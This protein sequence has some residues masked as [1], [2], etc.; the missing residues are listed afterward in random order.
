MIG[1]ETRRSPLWAAERPCQ[2]RNLS[3]SIYK[4]LS[5]INPD[6]FLN[7]DIATTALIQDG[8]GL[9]PLL[10]GMFYQV[11]DDGHEGHSDAD[12]HGCHEENLP[13]PAEDYDKFV[14]LLILL[15]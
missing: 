12:E 3:A 14:H 6:S 11:A 8:L 15:G 4:V 9:L 13:Q 7:P 5:E 1:R 2:I 10:A